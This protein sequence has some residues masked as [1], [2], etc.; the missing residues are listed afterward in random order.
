MLRHNDSTHP[1]FANRGSKGGV[2][3]P[4]TARNTVLI[5]FRRPATLAGFELVFFTIPSLSHFFF[6]FGSFLNDTFS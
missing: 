1:T 5:R 3:T 2:L 6:E 4:A